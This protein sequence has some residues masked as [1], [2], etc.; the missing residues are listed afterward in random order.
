M[1]RTRHMVR[2]RLL[3]FTFVSVWHI[4]PLRMMCSR[5]IVNMW[6]VYSRACALGM[7]ASS[8]CCSLLCLG[9]KSV[10]KSKDEQAL[11]VVGRDAKTADETC[12]QKTAQQY[13]HS[14]IRDSKMHGI[15]SAQSIVCTSGFCCFCPSRRRPAQFVRC[16]TIFVIFSFVCFSLSLS[17]PMFAG[18]TLDSWAYVCESFTLLLFHLT[19]S[20]WMSLLQYY[21]A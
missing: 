3:P 6:Y 16:S 20:C 9:L 7:G 17:L 1:H 11:A 19:S 2:E 5:L 15:L 4:S 12:Q 8:F 14:V 18:A 10:F 13:M 21:F